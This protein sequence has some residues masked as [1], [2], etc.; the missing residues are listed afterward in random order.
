MIYPARSPQER[1]LYFT[2]DGSCDI[3]SLRAAAGFAR[4]AAAADRVV[5]PFHSGGKLSPRSGWNQPSFC[6]T[7]LICRGLMKNRLCFSQGHFRTTV[8]TLFVLAPKIYFK[9]KETRRRLR[10]HFVSA[11]VDLSVCLCHFPS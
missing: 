1:A 6:L 3:I 5:R 9:K 4:E 11:P 10:V 7:P 2:S 8:L